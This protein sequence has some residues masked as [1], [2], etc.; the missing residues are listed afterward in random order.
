MTLQD[1]VL[2][3]NYELMTINND[4]YNGFWRRYR[5]QV[6]EAQSE[7]WDQIKQEARRLIEKY[8]GHP[9]VVHQ[10]QDYLDQLE[11]RCLRLKMNN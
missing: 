9:L 10:I 8:G 1:A 5:D 2:L 3:S 11:G 6:P 7:E 4:I